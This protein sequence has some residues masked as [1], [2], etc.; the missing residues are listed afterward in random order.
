MKEKKKRDILY[1]MLLTFFAVVFIVSAVLLAKNLLT[2]R[3]QDKELERLVSVFPE[4]AFPVLS[5]DAVRNGN[6]DDHSDDEEAD[7]AAETAEFWSQVSSQEW[8]QYWDNVAE[9]RF[10]TYQTLKAQN[11]DFIGWIHIEGT[12]ID[13]PVLQS[14]YEADFYLK[15]DFNKNSSSYGIPYLMEQCRTEEPK[16]NLLIYGHHM[17]N[18][19]MFAALQNYTKKSYYNQ[20]PYVQFDTLDR[21][22]TYQIVGVIKIDAAGDQSMWQQLLF[23]R[24]IDEFDQA[25][26]GFQQ[27]AFY[28]TGVSITQQDHLLALVTCEY[29]LKDGRLMVL[30]R[31]VN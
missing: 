9:K 28:S 14:I 1:Y 2:S 26:A 17:R 29:T 18:G 12:R 23:P 8:K 11:S 31:E 10:A 24:T 16:T 21:A 4:D 20:H 5:L 15:R 22:G 7:P 30:A 19:S 25:W 6:F 13:Y 3:S 27:Q